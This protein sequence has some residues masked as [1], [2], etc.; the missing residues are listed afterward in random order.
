MLGKPKSKD[1]N[2]V[3]YVMPWIIFLQFMQNFNENVF[4]LITP[5]IANTFGISP[6]TVSW[7]VSIAGFSFGVGGGI[8]AVLADI[9]SMKKIFSFGVIV[10][11]AGSIFG[12]IFQH[13]Y[14]A[15][16]IG[17]LIQTIGAGVI[18][19]CLIVFIARYVPE[20]HKAK[21]FGYTTAIFQLSAGVGH[22]LGGIITTY[23]SW[24]FGFLLP[25]LSLI[26][27]PAFIK[28]MPD[29]HLRANKLDTKGA[30]LLAV[31]ILLSMIALTNLNL[32]SFIAAV[33]F[34][35][36]FIIYCLSREKQNKSP[37]I[38]LKVFKNKRFSLGILIAFL[39]FGTQN[40][41][42]FIFPFIMEKVYHSPASVIG[43]IYLP[44]NIAAFFIGISI[45]RIVRFTG[46]EKSVYAGL[47]IIT[48]GL[49]IFALFMTQNILWMA[50]AL[51]LFSCGYPFFYV[52]FY[53][54]FTS[55]LPKERLG[56]G[57]GVFNI[58]IN[59]ATS[60]M[61][62]IIGLIVTYRVL[63]LDFLPIANITGNIANY[64]NIMFTL[65]ILVIT[66]GILFY[67]TF[68]GMDKFLKEK[69]Q[70]EK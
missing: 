55:V 17:R 24:Q 30:I 5:N 10:F 68:R 70:Y 8:Y 45:G 63:D 14:I 33:C 62:T 50:V 28:Y 64:S 44:T 3:F 47:I 57:M 23:I 31:V 19:G 67:S 2:P 39:V 46:R 26:C 38:S 54:C 69:E 7:I 18:P 1:I 21:Y 34:A 32:Y 42:F 66:A 20:S 13:F 6:A 11:A 35:I 41:M 15:V 56:T 52:G 36:A 53:D 59:L 16:I 58:I 40:G 25:V 9:I 61:P 12:F 43:L 48:S 22:F 60:L 37:F 4:Y 65:I 27:L 29:E 51:L 49:L